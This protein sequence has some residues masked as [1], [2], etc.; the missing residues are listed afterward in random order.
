MQYITQL[1]INWQLMADLKAN[2]T[3][4]PYPSAA[5]ASI[6][7]LT[8]LDRIKICSLN[9]EI[10]HSEPDQCNWYSDVQSFLFFFFFRFPLLFCQWEN[11]IIQTFVNS[12][13][14]LKGCKLYVYWMK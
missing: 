13:P 14:D 6:Q 5:T 2:G 12:K 10:Q 7:F 9:S 1:R 3:N 8:V 4:L 11:Q